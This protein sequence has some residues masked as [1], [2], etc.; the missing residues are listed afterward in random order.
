VRAILRPRRA[1]VKHEPGED[2]R[3]VDVREPPV[4]RRWYFRPV[5]TV[6][7]A[8]AAALVLVP[9]A[10][11]RPAGP[12]RDY[13]LYYVLPIGVPFVAFALDRL[14]HWSRWRVGHTGLDAVVVTLALARAFTPVLPVSG[15]ALFLAYAVGTGSCWAVR[16][17][18]LAV[19]A[20]VAYLKLWVWGDPTLWPG[21][22]G[23]AVAAGLFRL[24]PTRPGSFDRVPPD[25]R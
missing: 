6:G 9:V 4:S 19:L 13:L 11:L 16:L 1:A 24:L 18:A 8:L 25:G 17:T 12:G 14:E 21:V 3:I 22:A 15:H 23:G 20:E 10:L 7:A 2:E 5:G